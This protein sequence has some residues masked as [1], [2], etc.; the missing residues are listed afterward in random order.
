MTPDFQPIESGHGEARITVGA[1]IGY[2]FAGDGLDILCFVPETLVSF[3][4]AGEAIVDQTHYVTTGWSQRN[5]RGSDSDTGVMHVFPDGRRLI[6]HRSVP[7]LPAQ[8]ERWRKLAE[9]EME[10]V[11]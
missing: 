3:G 5:V 7:N 8:V 4:S 9:R 6:D 10:S 11:D 1:V 2:L